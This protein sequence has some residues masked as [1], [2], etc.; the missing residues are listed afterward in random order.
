MVL[1]HKD[2]QDLQVN[3]VLLDH[4]VHKEILVIINMMYLVKQIN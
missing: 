3:L 1:V 4:V 2:L